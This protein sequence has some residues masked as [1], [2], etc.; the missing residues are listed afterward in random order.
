MLNIAE[1][2]ELGGHA[3]QPFA[4]DAVSCGV[5]RP[6]D[7]QIAENCIS[8]VPV[9]KISRGQPT[10]TPLDGSR[11]RLSKMGPPL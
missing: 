11:L 7:D 10:R 1:T 5:S 4:A 6:N 9:F 3:P 8:K 2:T